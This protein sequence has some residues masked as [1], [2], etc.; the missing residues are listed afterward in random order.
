M[1]RSNKF[2]RSILPLIIANSIVCTG[3]LEYFVNR[4]IR[5]IGFVYIICCVVYYINLIFT[6][7]NILDTLKDV[8]PTNLARIMS[9]ITFIEN[10]LL[11]VVTIFVGFIRRK[12]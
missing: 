6:F 12:V 1:F 8:Q 7:T 3:L 9:V 4:T 2:Q 5:T 11:Y 10:P